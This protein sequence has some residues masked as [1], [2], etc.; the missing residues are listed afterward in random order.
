[1]EETAIEFRGIARLCAF[2]WNP[3][4]QHD[5]AN[6]QAQGASSALWMDIAWLHSDADFSKMTRKDRD[7]IT[8]ECNDAMWYKITSHPASMLCMSA[9]HTMTQN[10]QVANFPSYSLGLTHSYNGIQNV[11]SALIGSSFG[12]SPL[13]SIAHSPRARLIAVLE[14]YGIHV[15]DIWSSSLLGKY[16][17]EM[18]ILPCLPDRGLA[19]VRTMK[20]RV[21]IASLLACIDGT[22]PHLEKCPSQGRGMCG[23][24]GQV[25]M[26]RTYRLGT[27]LLGQECARQRLAPLLK[28]LHQIGSLRATRQASGV[29]RSSDLRKFYTTL[30]APW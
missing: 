25:K 10:E 13:G 21:N 22:I 15:A 8:F 28:V 6:D 26:T 9:I 1:L 17:Y 12:G 24:C 14:L 30:I 19:H 7:S 18:I 20:T 27:V 5:D 29:P 3:T 16:I 4:A 23:L 2:R 11:G